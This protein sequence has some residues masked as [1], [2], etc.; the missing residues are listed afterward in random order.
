MPVTSNDPVLPDDILPLSLKTVAQL[1]D[2]SDK[3]IRRWIQRGLLRSHKL[4]G[5]RVVRKRDLR[6]FLDQQAGVI[7]KEQP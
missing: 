3:T 1:V 7:G 5:S 6:T 2:K 4:G